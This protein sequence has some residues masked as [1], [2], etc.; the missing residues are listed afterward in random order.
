MI[1]T[2]LVLSAAALLVASCATKGEPEAKIV[3]LEVD[4]PVAASCVPATLAIDP[5]PYQTMK[6][7]LAAAH[8]AARYQMALGFVIALFDR[9]MQVEPVISS[10]RA[11]GAHP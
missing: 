7:Q 5:P 6:A 1:R 2:L 8:G 9:A 3:P 4:K 10:C 11:A